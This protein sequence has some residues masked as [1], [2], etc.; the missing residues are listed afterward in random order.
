MLGASRGK[1]LV[2]FFGGRTLSEVDIA[3][4]D[5]KKGE[6]VEVFGNMA[7]SVLSG[8]EARS[9]KKA[10]ADVANAAQKAITEAPP[11]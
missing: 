11:H 7:L 3:M 6:Y 4:I 10:W 2:E 8:A 9:R 5:A 1:A